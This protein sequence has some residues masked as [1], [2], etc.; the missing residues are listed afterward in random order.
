ME[1]T[2]KI[3]KKNI[4]TLECLA[5]C[6]NANEHKHENLIFLFFFSLFLSLSRK[7]YEE[8]RGEKW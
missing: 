1:R 3:A 6:Q 8:N 4:R 2:E 7:K 5:A